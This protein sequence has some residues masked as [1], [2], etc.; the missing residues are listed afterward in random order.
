[1][2]QKSL[3]S[4][5]SGNRPG[6]AP[7]L[8][9][10]FDGITDG[11]LVIDRSYKIVMYNKGMQNFMRTED[12]IEGLYCYFV[13]HH[14]NVPCHDCQAQTAFNNIQPPSRTRVCFRDNAKRQFEIWNFPIANDEGDV[15]YMVEYIRDVT[16]KHGMEKELMT[17]RRL[18]IIGE[19][20]A[21]TSHEIRNPLNAMAGAAHY[22][23]NEYKSDPKIQ[24][25]AG[26]IEE[27]IARLNK[28]ATE[29]L[30]SS[31]PKIS[32]GEKALITQALLKSLEVVEDDARKRKIDVQLFLDEDLPEVRYDGDRMQQVFINVLR[33]A[34]EAMENGGAIEIV[35]AVRQVNG[36]DYLEICFIDGGVGI[37]AELK[38]AV[39]ESF[40]TTKKTGTGLGLPIV[41]DIMK[42]HGGYVFI[43]PSFRGG[44]AVRIGLPI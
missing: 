21:K 10:I 23:I 6:T 36:E 16:E 26:M 41:R 5:K 2:E 38:D 15:D 28:V 13:C 19:V 40:Y 4:S 25:F 24:K 11:V 43:E 14:N 39:F 42:N 1:M 22:L 35:G 7:I 9:T 34:L 29:L 31:R 27:Q 33:N 37:P 17:S 3:S 30:D 8:Q 20:A 44:T 18:A 12:D 32:F